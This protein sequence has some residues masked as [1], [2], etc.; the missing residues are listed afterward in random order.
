MLAAAKYI[1]L[2]IDCACSYIIEVKTYIHSNANLKT[3]N[4]P[5]TEKEKEKIEWKN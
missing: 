3:E 5:I 1:D 4:L 2:A